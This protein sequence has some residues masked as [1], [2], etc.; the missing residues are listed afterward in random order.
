[1]CPIMGTKLFCW[2]SLKQQI[3]W[4]IVVILLCRKPHN[5]RSLFFVVGGFDG[6]GVGSGVVGQRNEKESIK[7]AAAGLLAIISTVGQRDG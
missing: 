2:I 3:S 4:S 6:Y 5:L 1:M 7:I